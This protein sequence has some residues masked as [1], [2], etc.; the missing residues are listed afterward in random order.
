MVY[1]VGMGIIIQEKIMRIKIIEK[2]TKEVL[3]PFSIE[4]LLSGN[5]PVFNL[6][7]VIISRCTGIKDYITKEEICEH[8]WVLD[9]TDYD[10]LW[11]IKNIQTEHN[12][13]APYQ[14]FWHQPE[15]QWQ[16]RLDYP[17]HKV[18][19]TLDSKKLQIIRRPY[20]DQ[21]KR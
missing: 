20:Y 21:E 16:M 7:A 15:A 10:D 8:D 19:E 18:R 2:K 1:Y 9:K 17:G 14:I 5:C 3:G 11:P 4:D 13:L 6:D 12:V